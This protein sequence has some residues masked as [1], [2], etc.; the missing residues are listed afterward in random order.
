MM[1]SYSPFK[2]VIMSIQTTWMK[3]RGYCVKKD[4]YHIMSHVNLKEL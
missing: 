2:K 3:L 1:E 4:K